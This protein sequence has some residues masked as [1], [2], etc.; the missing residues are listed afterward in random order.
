MKQLFLLAALASSIVMPTPV[1]AQAAAS[2]DESSKAI[3]AEVWA[4]VSSTVAAG[5]LDGMASTYH[6]DAVL[7]NANGTASIA[8]TLKRWGDG[9]AKAKREGTHSTVAF[10]FTKRQDGTDTAF[11]SGI[12]QLTEIS[13][14]GVSTSR[15]I[16]F[17]CLLVKHDGKW[18]ILM[19]R[20]F[21]D[22]AAAWQKLTP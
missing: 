15:F 19:E 13:A 17:E 9:M 22:P 14:A 1:P 11:E 18:R 16:P 6:P 12:F 2:S 21:D 10:R 7:V 20:Q 3:D 4:V 5:D 8:K